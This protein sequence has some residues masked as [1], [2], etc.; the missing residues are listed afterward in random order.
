MQ[1]ELQKKYRLFLIIVAY[2]TVALIGLGF[3]VDYDRMEPHGYLVYLIFALVLT[4]LSI[5]DSRIE[6]KPIP[7]SLYWLVL[8]AYSV[9]V[10]ICVI[11][12]H[13]VKRG[14][15]A[16]LLHLIGLFLVLFISVC[17]YELIVYGRIVY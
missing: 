1:I 14:L 9:A 12:A 15:K 6:G 10:P 2:L 5:V 8:I 11:R 13:G 16:I 4:H 3:Y 7:V 17:I